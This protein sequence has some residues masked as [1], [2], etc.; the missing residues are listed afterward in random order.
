ME[1]PK[2]RKK[3]RQLALLRKKSGLTQMDVALLS[4]GS[5][6]STKISHIENGYMTPSDLEVKVIAE[7]LKVTME[8]IR[9]TFKV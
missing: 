3:N 2:I 8:E 1:P 9:K 6:N 4:K 7:V 5:I